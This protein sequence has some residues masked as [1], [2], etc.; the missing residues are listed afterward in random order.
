[1][2]FLKYSHIHILFALLIKKEPLGIQGQMGI[3]GPNLYIF[4]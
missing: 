2:R 1:M 4:L 3:Q